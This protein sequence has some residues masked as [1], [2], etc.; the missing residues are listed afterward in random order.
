MA[1]LADAY[2]S[3]AYVRKDVE[4]QLL[5]GAHN[6]KLGIKQDRERLK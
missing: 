3:G 2:A 6:K 1:E 5:W 4:V